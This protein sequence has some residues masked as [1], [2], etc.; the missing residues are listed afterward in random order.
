MQLSFSDLDKSMGDKELMNF[1]KLAH[2]K[3]GVGLLPCLQGAWFTEPIIPENNQLA[4]VFKKKDVRLIPNSNCIQYLRACADL[5][6]RGKYYKLGL[7]LALIVAA[8]AHIADPLGFGL[9]MSVLLIVASPILMV[10]FV[11]I[12]G[13]HDRLSRNFTKVTLRESLN[14][15]MFR[16][17]VKVFIFIFLIDFIFGFLQELIK[18]PL[19]EASGNDADNIASVFEPIVS[20]FVDIVGDKVIATV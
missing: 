3:F 12:R 10:I 16:Y 11:S 6:R 1:M 17:S 19:F 13:R 18:F 4:V 15:E 8:I 2:K 14:K 20:E 9:L 5:K 7:T